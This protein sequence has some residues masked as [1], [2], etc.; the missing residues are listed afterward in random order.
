MF[1]FDP[2]ENPDDIGD[3]AILEIRRLAG[4]FGLELVEDD[5]GIAPEIL[6]EMIDRAGLLQEAG[7]VRAVIRALEDV[8]SDGMIKIKEGGSRRVRVAFDEAEGLRLEA[9]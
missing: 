3:L 6:F 5:R 4:S 2:I 1:A 7:G 9:A 8:L